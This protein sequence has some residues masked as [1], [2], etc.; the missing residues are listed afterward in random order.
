VSQGSTFPV[1]GNKT[2]CKEPFHFVKV[3]SGQPGAVA[4]DVI[5]CDLFA[6]EGFANVGS[7]LFIFDGPLLL[8]EFKPSCT[9]EQ[10]DPNLVWMV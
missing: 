4:F 9:G 10:V 3:C 8:G 2:G 5:Q 1:G 6:P 7:V